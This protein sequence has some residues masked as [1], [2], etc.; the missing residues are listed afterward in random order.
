[1]AAIAA[2]ASLN[3]H[4]SQ[5]EAF[6]QFSSSNLELYAGWITLEV[7]SVARGILLAEWLRTV[8][9]EPHQVDEIWLLDVDLWWDGD[10]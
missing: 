10:L 5:E 9:V 8:L 2:W 4:N 3:T 7:S 6:P 1:M